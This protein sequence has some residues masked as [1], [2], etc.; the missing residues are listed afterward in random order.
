MGGGASWPDFRH[1][2]IVNAAA[3]LAVT[4]RTWLNDL[5]NQPPLLTAYMDVLEKALGALGGLC[6]DEEN[7]QILLG[8]PDIG[9]LANDVSGIFCIFGMNRGN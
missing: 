6:Q 4:I 7:R 1:Y 9:P 5:V 2:N 8:H 3:N